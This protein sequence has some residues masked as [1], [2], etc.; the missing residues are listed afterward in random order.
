MI[1]GAAHRTA[2]ASGIRAAQNADEACEL[3]QSDKDTSEHGAVIFFSFSTLFVLTFLLCIFYIK[4]TTTLSWNS[5][6]TPQGSCVAAL[7]SW[8]W[9]QL[10]QVRVDRFQS[11]L[12][13]LH[14]L[15][16]SVRKVF[17]RGAAVLSSARANE[18]VFGELRRSHQGL[19]S[20]HQE[21]RAV[22]C[23]VF[24]FSALVSWYSLLKF[25]FR[26]IPSRL[27]YGLVPS[28]LLESHDFW[29]DAE[30]NLRGY[31]HKHRPEEAPHII[32]IELK[33]NTFFAGTFFC[34]IA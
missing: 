31:P 28:A 23:V 5:A 24:Y 4:K 11:V 10:H 15:V 22:C 18:R 32:Y 12:P 9:K 33:V 2:V 19:R 13:L 20:R 30:D 14:V 21:E 3:L 27:L 1:A 26:F 6:W 17:W 34:F 29:Q 8:V 16:R 25:G 7:G